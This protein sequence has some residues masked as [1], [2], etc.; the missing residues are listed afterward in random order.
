[1][2][3]GTLRLSVSAHI[4]TPTLFHSRSSRIRVFRLARFFRLPDG[5]QRS[6]AQPVRSSSGSAHRPP[7]TSSTEQSQQN[8]NRGCEVVRTSTC[9][10]FGLKA[11]TVCFKM[12]NIRRSGHFSCT[13]PPYDSTPLCQ[14]S[15]TNQSTKGM[16]LMG[17]QL[18]SAS[19]MTATS[20]AELRA[21][22]RRRRQ[23]YAL[24]L[25]RPGFLLTPHRL[26]LVIVLVGPRQ[27]SGFK[28]SDP[29]A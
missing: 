12:S 21:L 13:T 19:Q 24:P 7:K 18:S 20:G 9:A 17:E 11:Y 29:N 15:H 2:D 25:T 27:G 28:N 16:I 5:P 8:G 1:M 22:P 6:E 23:A 3:S 26:H 10:V 4:N 14:Q